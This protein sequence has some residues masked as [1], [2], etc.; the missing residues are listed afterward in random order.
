MSCAG[1]MAEERSAHQVLPGLRQSESR[2]VTRVAQRAAG[3]RTAAY[4]SNVASTAAGSESVSG[5]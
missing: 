2:G 5:H 1:R 4:R 3:D